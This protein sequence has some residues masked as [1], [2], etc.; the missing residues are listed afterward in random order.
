MGPERPRGPGG[1]AAPNPA[2]LADPRCCL[3]DN[4]RLRS[5]RAEAA[6]EVG[7]AFGAWLFRATTELC[8][9]GDADNSWDRLLDAKRSLTARP[10]PAVGGDGSEGAGLVCGACTHVVPDS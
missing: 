3:S 10:S 5:T 6:R 7:G 8:L 4:A 2:C 1:L 9:G